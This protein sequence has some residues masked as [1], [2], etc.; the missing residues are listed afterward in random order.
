MNWSSTSYRRRFSYRD[1][2]NKTLPP[3]ACRQLGRITRA[4]RYTA[5]RKISRGF[6]S[7]SRDTARSCEEVLNQVT[8]GVEM[9]IA[10]PR[11]L[12]I[13]LRWRVAAGTDLRSV[14]GAAAS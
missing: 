4:A 14:R 11:L 7:Q 1:F 5:A 12:P 9:A 10:F 6:G 8:S 13:Y 3:G 2:T